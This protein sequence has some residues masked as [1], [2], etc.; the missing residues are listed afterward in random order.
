[1]VLRPAASGTRGGDHER[2]ERRAVRGRVGGGARADLARGDAVILHR[3]P[4]T[5]F[6]WGFAR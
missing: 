3:L 2:H 1:M 6:A 4:M 5:G